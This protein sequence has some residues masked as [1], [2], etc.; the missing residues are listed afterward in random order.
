MT[1]AIGAIASAAAQRSSRSRLKS[2]VEILK[3]LP[4]ESQSKADLLA[5]VDRRISD[6][7]KTSQRQSDPDVIGIKLG[8]ATLVLGTLI[9]GG[10][11]FGLAV[12][13][14]GYLP[15]GSGGMVAFMIAITAAYSTLAIGG[16]LTFAGIV[17]WLIRRWVVKK[18]GRT[19]TAES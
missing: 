16:V 7:L 17:W 18:P 11:V 1:F 10:A 13:G 2:D 14:H 4:D 15:T 3:D 5:S 19:E 6:M 8:I 12:P 9:L